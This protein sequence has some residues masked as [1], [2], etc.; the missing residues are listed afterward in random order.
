M[1][2]NQYNNLQTI[3]PISADAAQVTDHSIVELT[4]DRQLVS[5]APRVKLAGG[6][7]PS[8]CKLIFGALESAVADNATASVVLH[9]AVAMDSVAGVKGGTMLTMPLT[10]AFAVTYGTAT[11]ERMIGGVLTTIRLAD[12]IATPTLTGFGTSLLAAYASFQPVAYSPTGNGIGAL[13]L[14]QLPAMDSVIVDIYGGAADDRF[15]LVDSHS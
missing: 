15:V 8:G 13:I 12:T 9:A 14:P 3:G 11:I 1:S 10:S 7:H 2:N 6:R 4:T 5:G